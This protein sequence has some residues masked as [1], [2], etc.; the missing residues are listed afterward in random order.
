VSRF[1]VQSAEILAISILLSIASFFRFFALS[2]KLVFQ[3]D[4]GRALLAARDILAG[5]LTLLGP[6]TSVSGFHLGPFFYYLIAPALWLAGYDPVGP[7]ILTASFGVATVLLLYFYGKRFFSWE[8]GLF[9]GL[10]FALSPHVIWQSRIALEPSPVPFFAVCWLFTITSWGVSKNWRWLALSALSIFLG[11]QLNFSFVAL[12]PATL[13]LLIPSLSLNSRWQRRLQMW[14]L[15]LLGILSIIRVLWQPST[16]YSY[17]LR[18]WSELTFPSSP[19]LALLL[20]SVF[21]LS[22][23]WF[24]WQEGR[25]GS[26]NRLLPLLSLIVF[27]FASFNLKTVSGDHSLAVLFPVPAVLSGIAWDAYKPPTRMKRIISI[28]IV[29]ILIFLL[30]AQAWNYLSNHSDHYLSEH[31]EVAN[32]IIELSEGKPYRFI[33][34]GHLDV[35]EAADDHYQYLLWR[36]GQSPVESYRREITP[37]TKD[38]WNS[39]ANI[40]ALRTI[41]LYQSP[42]NFNEYSGYQEAEEWNDKWF[43]VQDETP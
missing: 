2:E 39:Q 5:K 16:S 3:G 33:Y 8:A 41:V 10:L 14:S 28:L 24:L 15:L 20:P 21:L 23:G 29:S 17:L 1:R 19:I 25:I 13:W 6:E 42:F 36:S 35:Y 11:T 7:A 40:P 37:G 26:R 30:T 12:F 38:P 31:Q 34:R 43:A 22:L 32:H 18:I 9:M 4:Q 27:C